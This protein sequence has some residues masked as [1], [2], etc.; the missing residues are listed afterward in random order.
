[1][2][3]LILSD[4]IYFIFTFFSEEVFF[5]LFTD[6]V[7]QFLLIFEKNAENVLP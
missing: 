6:S 7:T 2:F 5:F 4:K 1:M 3:V